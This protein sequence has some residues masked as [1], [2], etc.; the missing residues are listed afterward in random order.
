MSSSHNRLQTL[1]DII[2]GADKKIIGADPINLTD[3][4]PIV[5]S[6]RFRK[7]APILTYDSL[8]EK[9]AQRSLWNQIGITYRGVLKK[10]SEQ[11]A[12]EVV[13]DLIFSTADY[14]QRS[15]NVVESLGDFR[16]I[17]MPTE[18]QLMEMRAHHAPLIEIGRFMGALAIRQGETIKRDSVSLFYRAAALDDVEFPQYLGGAISSHQHR[19][20][21]WRQEFESVSEHPVVNKLLYAIHVSD[22]ELE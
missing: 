2:P 12:L 14:P 11:K 7:R 4:I 22:H 19:I 3:A 20:R 10:A 1:S 15:L 13:N 9:I 5:D 17:D 8:E 18:Q 16:G 6:N 21:F